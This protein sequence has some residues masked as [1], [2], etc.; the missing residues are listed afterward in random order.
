MF[1]SKS[2]IDRLGD[3]LRK[4]RVLPGD[5]T[6]LNDYRNSFSPAYQAV[7]AVIRDKFLLLPTGRPEKSTNS[8]ID[9]LKREKIRLSQIQDIA[10]CRVVVSDIFVQEITIHNFREAQESEAIFQNLIIVDRRIKPTYDYRAVHLIIRHLDKLVEVQLRTALQHRWAELSEKFSDVVDRTIKYGGG[11]LHIRLLLTKWSE[12][13]RQFEDQEYALLSLVY[14]FPGYSSRKDVDLQKAVDVEAK[15]NN[16]KQSL[17]DTMEE[18]VAIV[19][20]ED[21]NDFLN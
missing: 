16:V 4:E 19:S 11:D 21:K 12:L 9:K 14:T 8:I 7:T 10:G 2:Q 15:L 13:I 18:L 3:K 1:L 17:F 6:A 5:L 20:R